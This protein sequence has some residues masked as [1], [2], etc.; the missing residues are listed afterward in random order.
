MSKRL[1]VTVVI[2]FICLMAGALVLTI[3]G[4]DGRADATE[5]TQA[6]TQGS[7][8]YIVKDYNGKVAVFREG[9][10]TPVSTTEKSVLDL[11]QRD[12]EDLTAGVEVT[13]EEKLRKLIEDYCS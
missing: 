6:V 2:A 1:V 4:G 8:V 10:T 12:R 5:P 9:E 11:P 7:D 13:G 3:T